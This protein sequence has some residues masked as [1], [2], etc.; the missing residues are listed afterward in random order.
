[1][2]IRDRYR[3]EGIIPGGEVFECYT[4]G[5]ALA[6]Y[7]DSGKPA[8]CRFPV[9]KGAVLALGMEYGA[10]YLM[11]ETGAVPVPYGNRDLY[12]VSYTHLD[13][14]KRQPP[15]RRAVCIRSCGSYP[16][17]EMKHR[18]SRN[19]LQ[20]LILLKYIIRCFNTL[21]SAS[22]MTAIT[23]NTADSLDFFLRIFYSL[24]SFINKLK[25]LL[26]L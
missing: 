26:N 17:D 13:V 10:E 18:I 24:I 8:V 1:M 20:S 3:G 15:S 5:E 21:S 6:V 22:K 19:P 23:V 9:G 11:Q 14:Y 16:S 4:G 12:P 7:E 2:C 25:I